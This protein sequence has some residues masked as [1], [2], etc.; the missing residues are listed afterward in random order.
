MNI[1]RDTLDASVASLIKVT[2]TIKETKQGD[3][4]RLQEEYD[5]LVQ[6]LRQARDTG[7]V[8]N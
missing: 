3:A 5:R 2:Q 4:S 7:L 8:P 6:G 1:R